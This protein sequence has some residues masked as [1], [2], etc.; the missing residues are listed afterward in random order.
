[1]P[2]QQNDAPVA[3]QGAKPTK[4]A[5]TRVMTAAFIVLIAVTTLNGLYQRGLDSGIPLYYTS[6]GDSATVGGTLVAIF[7]VASMVM[8]L[9]GG[10]ITD[11]TDH[12]HALLAG[13]GMLLVGAVLPAIWPNFAVVVVA[14]II[15]GCGFAF[16]SN[17]ISVLVMDTAPKKKLGQRISYKG[18]GTS[19]AMMFGASI[20]TW[21]LA[22]CSYRV[23][24]AVYALMALAGLVL[25]LL[26]SRTKEIE[27]ARRQDAQLRAAAPRRTVGWRETLASYRLPQAVPYTVIQLLR[28][29]PKGACLSFMLVY[30]KH[31]GFGTG[32]LF[33]I[34][35]GLATLICRIAFAGAFN[36][37][38]R[39]V[40]LPMMLIDVLG[41][42]LL[43]IWPNWGVLI[44]AAIC[45]GCSIG[46][47][48]PALKTLTSQSVGK[49]H[50]GVANG[51]LQFMG[52]I[53]RAL[54]AFLGGVCIDMTSQAHIPLIIC[55]FAAV[56]SVLTA[57]VLAVGTRAAH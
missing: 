1:M 12:I 28:R 19:L 46:V 18:I 45:Y 57:F 27:T 42:G 22:T 33:F 41:F 54:G 2:S 38:N 8:R 20:A 50:W 30:A 6:I 11:T 26:I 13:M 9:V 39:W 56:G 5:N 48:S 21:L 4:P 16:A 7:T 29:L 23:F 24:Y 15:Q 51:E 32:A 36:H 55:L 3:S 52:D 35:A 17:V 37:I 25:V 34:V 53:G 44:F 47:M 10:R 49:A 31:N 14:R 43:A 40:L